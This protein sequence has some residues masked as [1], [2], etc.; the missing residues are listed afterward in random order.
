MIAR[1]TLARQ[2]LEA[3]HHLCLAGWLAAREGTGW[4]LGRIQRAERPIMQ[5]QPSDPN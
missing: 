3:K 2:E 1:G 4:S 5:K